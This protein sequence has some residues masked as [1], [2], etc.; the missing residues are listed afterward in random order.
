MFLWGKQG[1]AKRQY[2]FWGYMS[3]QRGF[4]PNFCM[5]FRSHPTPVVQSS[6]PSLIKFAPQA[7]YIV[8]TRN[9]IETFGK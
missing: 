8:G 6:E 7:T 3:I 5:Y 9:H 1:Q 2:P 4:L